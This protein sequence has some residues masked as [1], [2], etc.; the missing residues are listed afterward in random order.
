MKS[1]KIVLESLKTKG[2]EHAEI[3][4]V[5]AFEAVQESLPKILV[6]TETS[7]MEKGAATLLTTIL[8][9]LKASFEKLVDFD[10]DGQVG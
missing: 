2:I 3:V 5:K 4:C 1:L 9:P 8:P 7:A 10:K 6:D